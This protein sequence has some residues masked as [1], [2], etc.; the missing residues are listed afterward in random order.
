MWMSKKYYEIEVYVPYDGAKSIFLS[1]EKLL[2][3]LT[4]HSLVQDAIDETIMDWIEHYEKDMY[5]DFDY[6]NLWGKFQCGRFRFFLARKGFHI[7]EPL[8]SVKIENRQ[9]LS[10]ERY[11]DIEISECNK[12]WK[13]FS[14]EVCPVVCK[15]EGDNNGKK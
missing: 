15:R 2:D 13:D 4:F 10:D 8:E 3:D 14:I 5:C 9:I 1:H 12:C 6:W 7:I 11:K